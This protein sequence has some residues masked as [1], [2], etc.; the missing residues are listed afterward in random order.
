MAIA[1][2]EKNSNDLTDIAFSLFASTEESVIPVNTSEI[3]TF[4]VNND[5]AIEESSAIVRPV[6][7]S[8]PGE[9]DEP[10]P[11]SDTDFMHWLR[12]GL[13]ENKIVVNDTL[14]R[15][16]MVEGKAFLVSPEIFKLYIKSTTG[17]TGDEWKQVQKSFQKL[18]LHQRGNEGVNIWTI[19]VRGP[20]KTRR[21]KGYLI[22]NPA[23]IFGQS[24]PEDNPYLSVMTQ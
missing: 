5:R 2:A 16:H 24:V 19:E 12:N 11:P 1:I 18:K 10:L 9:P 20:R 7:T 13:S 14:A 17:Q 3:N 22:N 23:E 8:R 4:G 15:V 6:T 21:V